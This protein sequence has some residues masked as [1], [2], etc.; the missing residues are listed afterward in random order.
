MTIWRREK[1]CSCRE[2]KLGRPA[3]RYTDWVISALCR[4]CM[5]PGFL[6]RLHASKAQES[7]HDISYLKCMLS[8]ALPW[9]LW[10]PWHLANVRSIYSAFFIS[11]HHTGVMRKRNAF[12]NVICPSFLEAG[13]RSYWRERVVSHP[14]HC[15]YVSIKRQNT[16]R[17]D[18]FTER[19]LSK[20]SLP[21]HP[22]RRFSGPL[23]YFMTWT[24]IFFALVLDSF[25]I[26]SYSSLF[27]CFFVLPYLSFSF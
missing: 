8:E 16:I 15:W 27:P 3:R 4:L 21:F 18:L 19:V 12:L 5:S 17:A 11:R 14:L 24:Y 7:V 25:S 22:S 6:S 26:L 20:F 9:I 1:N 10:S 13:R 2:S 23:H